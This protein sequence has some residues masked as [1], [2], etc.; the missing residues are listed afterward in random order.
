M[1]FNAFPLQY[2]EFKRNNNLYMRAIEHFNI[3]LI[4]SLLMLNIISSAKLLYN[5]L[6]IF[7]SIIVLH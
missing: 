4:S 6:I 5:T 3:K 1:Q 7:I 2:Y